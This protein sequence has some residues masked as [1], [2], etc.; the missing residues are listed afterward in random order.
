MITG[1]RAGAESTVRI[2]PGEMAAVLAHAECA[3][4]NECCGVLIGRCDSDDVLVSR[5]LQTE[6]AHQ[7]RP[8]DRFEIAPED[9]LRALRESRHQ[10]CDVVG[11]YHSH[12]DQAAMP[13]RS[14]EEAAWPGVSYLIVSVTG[15]TAEEV[16]SWRKRGAALAEEKLVEEEL[17]NRAS[18]G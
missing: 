16:K 7:S 18:D 15:G 14:D 3:Y 8:H 2:R 9:L 4:P 11:Y 5:I 12:P 10:G 17:V 13:S 1:A 6:N